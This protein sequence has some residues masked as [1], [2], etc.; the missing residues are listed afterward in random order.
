MI[1]RRKKCEKIEG[2]GVKRSRLHVNSLLV[3][4]LIWHLI[5]G[6][7]AVFS[8]NSIINLFLGVVVCVCAWGGSECQ[9]VAQRVCVTIMPPT[10]VNAGV[11]VCWCQCRLGWTS[12]QIDEIARKPRWYGSPR[13]RPGASWLLK[14]SWE[15][16]PAAGELYTHVHARACVFVLMYVFMRQSIPTARVG[17]LPWGLVSPAAGETGITDSYWV[18]CLSPADGGICVANMYI[19]LHFPQSDLHPDQPE[20]GS[21]LRDFWVYVCVSVYSPGMH[22]QPYHCFGPGARSWC[23]LASVGLPDLPSLTAHSVY[24]DRARRLKI[25]QCGCW[26]VQLNKYLPLRTDNHSGLARRS[27]RVIVGNKAKW[28]RLATEWPK[29]VRTLP[30]PKLNFILCPP[31]HRLSCGQPWQPQQTPESTQVIFIEESRMWF[32]TRC[33]RSEGF[34]VF[35]G[36]KIMNTEMVCFWKWHYWMNVSW[37]EPAWKKL[38]HSSDVRVGSSSA[39]PQLLSP[40]SPFVYCKRQLDSVLKA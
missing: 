20:R 9:T 22:A 15:S 31:T 36:Y 39:H 19:H 2:Q 24:D 4:L 32:K 16:W 17:V 30:W 26:G 28:A 37:G 10:G 1:W 11:W 7:C 18:E 5:S 12:W 33:N 38:P 23:N 40:R 13:V 14:G 6:I 25:A 27:H 8:L 34:L 29:R 35:A 3:S 21:H